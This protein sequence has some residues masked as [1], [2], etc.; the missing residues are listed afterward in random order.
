MNWTRNFKQDRPVET[1]VRVIA[2]T[3]RYV[4]IGDNVVAS[5]SDNNR[6]LV[7]VGVI[8]AHDQL[9]AP[10]ARALVDVVDAERNIA[11]FVLDRG[12]VNRI[13][14]QGRG[15]HIRATRTGDIKA[16]G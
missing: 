3:G 16:R 8:G 10:T 15:R 9:V 4:A 2:V 1:R 5:R 11:D 12:G 14:R 13:E 6:N 7:S